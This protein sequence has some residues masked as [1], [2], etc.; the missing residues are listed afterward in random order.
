MLLMINQNTLIANEASHVAGSFCKTNQCN[1]TS[2][3]SNHEFE[4][5]KTKHVSSCAKKSE[6]TIEPCM[7][8]YTTH[9]TL[10]Y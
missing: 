4:G 7:T 10:Y 3:E 1:Q 2:S 9:S 5:N 6:K 8:E